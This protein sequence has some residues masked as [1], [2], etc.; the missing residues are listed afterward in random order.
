VTNNNLAPQIRAPFYGQLVAA[1]AIGHHPEVQVKSLDL[2]RDDLSAYAIY[3]AEMLARYVVINLDEWNSTT[4][5]SRPSQRVLLDMPE[6]LQSAEVTRLTGS[7]ASA[8]QGISWGGISW[9]Y[10]AGRLR[11]FGHRDIE[12]LKVREGFTGFQI[13]SSEAVVVELGR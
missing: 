2:G 9:N 6:H 3:E 13:E 10:T 12:A 4:P 1:D 7:G 11:E 5:Y 8:D